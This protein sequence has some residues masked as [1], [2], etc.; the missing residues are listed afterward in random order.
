[1]PR[2]QFTL[3]PPTEQDAQRFHTKYICGLKPDD[4]YTWIRGTREGYGAINWY[5]T[6]GKVRSANAHRVSYFLHHG[7]DP[8]PFFVLHSCDNPICPNPLH[9]FLGTHDDNM[10]DKARKW[11][12]SHCSKHGMAKITEADVREMRRR[13]KASGKKIK[14]FV[15]ELMPEYPMLCFSSIRQILTG[16]TWKHVTAD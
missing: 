5:D 8:G 7:I 1:M 4:C 13:H 15:R 14:P 6:E 9:L 16:T 12:Q 11:R 10:A 2:T 3:A